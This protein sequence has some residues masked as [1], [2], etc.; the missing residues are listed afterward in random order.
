MS[1]A[2]CVGAPRQEPVFTVGDVEIPRGQRGELS[3]EGAQV[4]TLGFH[5]MIDEGIEMDLQTL[6]F[7]SA[8]TQRCLVDDFIGGVTCNWDGPRAFLGTIDIVVDESSDADT[9]RH[10]M[11]ARA[12]EKE[13][14]REFTVYVG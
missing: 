7:D 1:L 10:E 13:F 8:E 2:G 12:I 4:H 3:F 5:P 9:Y 11:K 14:H 6:Q